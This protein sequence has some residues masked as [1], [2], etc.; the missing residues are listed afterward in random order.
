VSHVTC[1]ITA[2]CS[3]NCVPLKHDVKRID[4]VLVMLQPVAGNDLRSAAADAVVVGL[5]EFAF[6]EHVEAFVTR[7]HGLLVRRAQVGPHQAVQLLHRVPGL[8]HLVAGAAAFGLAG[9]LHAMALHVEQPAVVA[10]ADAALFDL[11]VI[12]GRA[13]MRAVRV[14]QAGPAGLV[15]KQDQVLAQHPH[16]ARRVAGVGRG[17]DRV[18]VAPEQFAHRRAG[19]DLGQLLAVARLRPA[20]GGAGVR[21]DGDDAGVHSAVTP[22]ALISSATRG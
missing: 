19:A 8:A 13:A 14:D 9:L 17:A 7:Q 20:I 15:A 16:L 21:G 4:Q 11:A 22:A 18:P 2:I 1:G 5:Q 6:V 12:Q 10:A 3:T